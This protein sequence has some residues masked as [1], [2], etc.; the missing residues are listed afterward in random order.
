MSWE[1]HGEWLGSTLEISQIM[2]DGSVF[3]RVFPRTAWSVLRHC[4]YS[5][6]HVCLLRFYIVDLIPHE[7]IYVAYRWRE[8]VSCD[9][10]NS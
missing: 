2:K 10:V 3:P 8:A 4:G 6:R 1:S 9:P 5:R 7:A